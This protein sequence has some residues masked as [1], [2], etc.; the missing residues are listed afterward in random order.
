MVNGNEGFGEGPDRI[1]L[2]KLDR[3]MQGDL[4][5][6]EAEALRAAVSR[7][8]E[9]L[10]YMQRNAS[11]K[12]GLRIEGIRSGA[13]TGGSGRTTPPAEN[14]GWIRIRDFLSLRS[15]V[16][17]AGFACAFALALGIGLWTWRL[18][19]APPPLSETALPGNYRI[20]GS[21]EA[22]FRILIRDTESDTGQLISA[23]NGDTLGLSY[24]SARPVTAQVWYREE[25]GQALPMTGTAETIPLEPAMS[26]RQAGPRI[27]LEGD[28]NRQTVW[29]VWSAA[30]FTSEA[31]RDALDGHAIPELRIASFRMVRQP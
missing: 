11:L 26:W 24:R 8:P 19:N 13:S 2:W 5:V 31:A 23:R 1:S 17:G 10:A 9:A 25:G 14:P 18:Q 15:G 21:G 30:P 22:E 3:L 29:V 7:S 27:V 20:K 4:P 12:S 16:R 6:P 28:W